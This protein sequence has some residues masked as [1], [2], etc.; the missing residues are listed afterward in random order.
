MHRFSEMIFGKRFLN[1]LNLFV[2]MDPNLI[3]IGSIVHAELQKQHRTV[4]WL[5]QQLSIKRPNCYRILH[6]STLQ[7]ETLFRVSQVLHPDF[8]ADYSAQLHSIQKQ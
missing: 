3:H 6:A 7:T 5:A 8:F 1:N 2:T 4:T